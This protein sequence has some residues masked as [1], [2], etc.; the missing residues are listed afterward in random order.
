[1]D[2]FQPKFRQRFAVSSSTQ[3][4]L[5]E[6]WHWYE[7]KGHKIKHQ[8]TFYWQYWWILQTGD[9]WQLRPDVSLKRVSVTGLVW[10]WAGRL[11]RCS[12]PAPLQ[13]SRSSCPISLVDCLTLS[14]ITGIKENYRN[15]VSLWWRVRQLNKQWNQQSSNTENQIN[16]V[17]FFNEW[18]PVVPRG[19]PV[20]TITALIRGSGSKWLTLPGEDYMP[21]IKHMYMYHV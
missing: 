7:M 13:E 6:L 16:A 8:L 21:V 2:V 19:V 3:N 9:G 10:Q 5:L 18:L 17:I 15:K 11:P 20:I 1:M 14:H 12:L 4:Y